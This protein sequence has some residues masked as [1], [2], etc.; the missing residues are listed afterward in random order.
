MKIKVGIVIVAVVAFMF[1]GKDISHN[2]IKVDADI[3]KIAQDKVI[4]IQKLYN[5]N[6]VDKIYSG[7]SSEF[8]KATSEEV[9][10][11]IMKEK[12]DIWKIK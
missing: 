3:R 11:S 1:F 4:I 7:T 5:Q 6:E 10:I 8:K 12:T 9:F 2:V